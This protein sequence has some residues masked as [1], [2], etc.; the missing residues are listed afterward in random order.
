MKN[1]QIKKNA[2]PPQKY[3]RQNNSTIAN[4]LLSNIF[5]GF[6]FGM[7]SSLGHAV[8]GNILHKN[9]NNEQQNSEDICKVLKESLNTC[10]VQGNKCDN[11]FDELIKNKCIE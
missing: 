10:L 5:T 1:S 3:N 4:S 6:T 2:P 11:V 7:G 8:V 9:S